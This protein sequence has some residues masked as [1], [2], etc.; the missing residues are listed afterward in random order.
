[1]V[2]AIFADL[3]NGTHGQRHFRG[4]DEKKVSL[5]IEIHSKK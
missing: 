4:S 3:M 2:R 1:M 5:A